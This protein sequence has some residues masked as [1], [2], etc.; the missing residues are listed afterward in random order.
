MAPVLPHLAEDA[1]QNLPFPRP[2]ISVFEAGWAAV[3]AEFRLADGEVASTWDA[4]LALKDQANQ[5]MEAARSDKFLGASTEA[6]I[7][8]FVEDSVAR[9]RLAR[10]A[11]TGNGVDE[12]RYVLITS[13]AELAGSEAEARLCKY[14]Q[15]VQIE[16]LGRVVIGVARADGSRCNRCW[17]YSTGVGADAEHPL[18]CERCLPVVRGLGFKPAAQAA[19]AAPAAPPTDATQAL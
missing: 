7:L 17:N 10:Q 6:K 18:L 1:W 3:P 4:L 15:E 16:G 2:T 12:L 14:H 11:C 8:V 5:V 19:A 9:D 13:R